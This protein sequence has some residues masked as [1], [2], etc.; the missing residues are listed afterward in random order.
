MA[1]VQKAESWFGKAGLFGYSWRKGLC[2]G[3]DEV[4]NRTPSFETS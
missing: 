2:D 4:R 1:N 3:I